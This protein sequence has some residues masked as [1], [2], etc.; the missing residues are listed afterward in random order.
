[1]KTFI[2]KIINILNNIVMSIFGNWKCRMFLSLFLT[3]LFSIFLQQIECRINWFLLS[4]PC[5][6]SAL[7]FISCFVCFVLYVIDIKVFGKIFLSW[8]S[9]IVFLFFLIEVF[10]LYQFPNIIRG[11]AIF[12]YSYFSFLLLDNFLPFHAQKK[13]DKKAEDTLLGREQLYE[14]FQFCIRKM[15]FGNGVGKTIAIYGR[16]GEGKTHLINYLKR[17]LSKNVDKG[18]PCFNSDNNIYKGEFQIHTINVWNYKDVKEAWTDIINS[19]MVNISGSD[20]NMRKRASDILCKIIP[21]SSDSKF[22]TIRHLLRLLNGEMDFI[23]DAGNSSL[24]IEKLNIRLKGKRMLIIFDDIDRA[25]INIIRSLLSIIDRLKKINNLFVICAISPKEIGNLYKFHG[26]DEIE[27][28]GYLDKLFDFSIHLPIA[29]RTSVIEMKNWLLTKKYSAY[30]LVKEFLNG[31]FLSFDTPRQLERVLSV[32][33]HT[34]WMYFRNVSGSSKMDSYLEKS[35]Y[36]TIFLVVILKSLYEYVIQEAYG[37]GK[38]I[39]EFFCTYPPFLFIEPLESIQNPSVSPNKNNAW[40]ISYPKTYSTCCSDELLKSLLT[41]LMPSDK[42][43]KE[44][45][46][47]ALNGDYAKRIY[48]WDW[49]CRAFI[50]TNNGE[51]KKPIRNMLIDFFESPYGM[52]ERKQ[53]YVQDLL[54]YAVDNMQKESSSD[55]YKKFISQLF[56]QEFHGESNK[57]NTTEY[58]DSLSHCF[59]SLLYIYCKNGYRSDM[60]DILIEMVKDMPFKHISIKTKELLLAFSSKKPVYPIKLRSHI[61]D[62]ESFPVDRDL[63]KHKDFQDI[64][65]KICEQYMYRF[66]DVLFND[67]HHGFFKLNNAHKYTHVFDADKE[68]K[69]KGL[70]SEKLLECCSKEY[71]PNALKFLIDYLVMPNYEGSVQGV[72]TSTYI[73]ELFEPLI[74]KLTGHESQYGSDLPMD[75][76]EESRK[77]VHEAMEAWEAWANDQKKPRVDKAEGNVYSNGARRLEEKLDAIIKKKK[78]LGN[79]KAPASLSEVNNTKQ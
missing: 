39:L 1:M 48:L 16:W 40:V 78:E 12:I 72:Q 5:K 50:E 79:D 27:L 37:Q 74:E 67:T 59:F 60:A 61:V 3:V 2:N 7:F 17:K 64:T 65:A 62:A 70:F 25:N 76:L 4:F 8:I 55:L 46:V 6:Q 41:N 9:L 42:K 19:I 32:L 58:I 14:D 34:E 24:N 38:N 68:M 66:L 29:S 15:A 54:S 69:Y 18:A 57:K 44:H 77:S 22:Q 71:K 33:A 30:P 47:S 75:F 36:K 28:Q 63:I 21:E 56:K 45:L 20:Y 26:H 11:I 49:Q 52:D 53:N 13:D 23:D 35:G 73:V 51:V 43:E 10:Y 31:T